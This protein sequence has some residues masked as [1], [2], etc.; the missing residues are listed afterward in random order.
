MTM[1]ILRMFLCLS[2]ALGFLACGKPAVECRQVYGLDGKIQI[3]LPSGWNEMPELHASADIEVGSEAA[4]AY[5]LVVSE[6]KGKLPKETLE[7]YSIYTRQGLEKS[8]DFPQDLGPRRLKI[9][10]IPALQYEIRAY[11][12]SGNKLVYLHTV[13]ETPEYFHQIVGWTT[14]EGFKQNGAVLKSLTESFR[15]NAVPATPK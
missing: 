9:N 14:P 6:P 3:G 4:D 7:D 8:L 12:K 1:H 11:G 15:E 13:M 10:G 5:F 2:M